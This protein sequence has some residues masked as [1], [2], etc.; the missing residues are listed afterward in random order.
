MCYVNR[1]SDLHNQSGDRITYKV[2]ISSQ[3]RRGEEHLLKNDSLGASRPRGHRSRHLS[4]PI[5]RYD[6]SH[7][8]LQESQLL[9]SEQSHFIL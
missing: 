8:P 9:H 1:I 7:Q 5:R 2:Q 3:A 4:E 6:E